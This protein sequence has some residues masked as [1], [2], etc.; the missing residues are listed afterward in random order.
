M[1][2]ITEDQAK[3][4]WCPHARELAVHKDAGNV[5]RLISG[6]NRLNGGNVPACLGSLCM[7]WRF[8]EEKR[9]RDI[10]LVTSDVVDL[11]PRVGY[12]GLSGKPEY[13]D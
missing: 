11:T 1:P 4:R 8:A 6:Y 13:G 12:C 10:D 2:F 5:G 7:A 3:N 9:I